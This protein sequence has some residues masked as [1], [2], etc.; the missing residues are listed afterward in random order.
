MV[1]LSTALQSGLMHCGLPLSLHW[2]TAYVQPALLY[3]V[4]GVLGG[5]ALHA[6]AR[7]ELRKVLHFSEEKAEKAEG[8][9]GASQAAPQQAAGD[10]GQQGGGA[11]VGKKGE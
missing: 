3:I 8:G 6:W 11:G 7:G 9:E 2:C 1:P 10:R 5:L 4:P